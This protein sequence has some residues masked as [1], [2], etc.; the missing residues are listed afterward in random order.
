[1]ISTEYKQG[2]AELLVVLRHCDKDI[3]SKIP[4]DVIRGLKENAEDIEVFEEK[5]KGYHD[6]LAHIELRQETMALL[7]AI[8]RKY[9]CTDEER[10]V[11]DK[12][13]LTAEELLG[14]VGIDFNS[15]TKEQ[16]EVQYQETNLPKE[17]KKENIFMKFLNK[18]KKLFKA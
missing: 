1:M 9:L 16:I 7:A 13:L 5:F 11:Y 17:I 6:D 8:Y 18:I 2:I 10:A 4:L 15:Q 14:G 3:I 12:K